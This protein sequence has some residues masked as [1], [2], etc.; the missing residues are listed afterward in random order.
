[1][2]EQASCVISRIVEM[3]NAAYSIALPGYEEAQAEATRHKVLVSPS[4][5]GRDAQVPVEDRDNGDAAVVEPCLNIVSPSLNPLGAVSKPL[6]I[7]DLELEADDEINLST[8]NC[9]HLV[10][11][12]FGDIDDSFMRPS[13]PKRAKHAATVEAGR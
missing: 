11:C 9:E 1:M 7:P 8:E 6:A 12:V 13:S 2:I 5:H 3:T 10:D 4:H